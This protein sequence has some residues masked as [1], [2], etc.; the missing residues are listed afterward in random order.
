MSTLPQK[1]SSVKKLFASLDNEIAEF[2]KS[3]GLHCLSGCGECCKKP[4]I[5]AT[6]LEFLPLALQFYDEGKAEDTL[7]HLNENDST[8]CHVFR[9]HVTNFGGL[10]SEYPNRGLICRLFG[11]SARRNKEGQAELVTCKFIKQDQAKEF[12]RVCDDLKNGKQIPVMS[13]Y[14]SRL[15]SIDPSLVE[16][17]PINTAMKKALEVVLHYYAYRK[18]KTSN[19]HS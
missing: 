13:D 3:S 8:L 1:V 19:S 10:C 15:S 14:Y 11:Y 5:E 9:P 12:D 6:P 4:D 2:Q 18:R 16:F 7:N 17:F